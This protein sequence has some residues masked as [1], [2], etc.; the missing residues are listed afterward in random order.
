[1]LVVAANAPAPSSDEDPVFAAFMSF[2]AS[3]ME[4]RPDQLVELDS[5]RIE[6]ASR[7]V[8]G[9]ES[10]EDEDLGEALI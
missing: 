4:R 9:V 8:T 7:L 2:L 1:M 5:A 6:E 10:D 3:D